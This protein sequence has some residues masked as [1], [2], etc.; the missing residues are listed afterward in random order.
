MKTGLKVHATIHLGLII[1]HFGNYEA[2][3]RFYHYL[4]K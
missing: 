3:H 2:T 1:S 4:T